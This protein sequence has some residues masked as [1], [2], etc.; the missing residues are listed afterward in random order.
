[1]LA[2]R[3]WPTGRGKDSA[4]IFTAFVVFVIIYVQ[5]FTY[6]SDV[7][8]GQAALINKSVNMLSLCSD[9]LNITR[10]IK[11]SWQYIQGDPA[12][13]SG[14]ADN[15]VD[16]EW[17]FKLGPLLTMDDPK[18]IRFLRQHVLVPPSTLPYNMTFKNFKDLSDARRHT[19]RIL[20][21]KYFSF[22]ELVSVIYS[23][24]LRTH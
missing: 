21:P 13:S 5:V 20:V 3:F 1:M 9:F 24:T 2:L 19:S 11:Y 16:L 6:F 14:A 4:W 10:C 18:L 15:L 22:P 8:E 7:H 12:I 23:Q 17:P